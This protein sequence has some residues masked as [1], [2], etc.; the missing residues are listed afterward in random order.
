MNCEPPHP[1]VALLQHAHS[2]MIIAG[3]EAA[4]MLEGRIGDCCDDHPSEAAHHHGLLSPVQQTQF[5]SFSV[6]QASLDS[7]QHSEAFK[8]GY[9]KASQILPYTPLRHS[10]HEPAHA[11][12]HTEVGLMATFYHSCHA[13]AAWPGAVVLDLLDVFCIPSNVL[14]DRFAAGS[15]ARGQHE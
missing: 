14:S 11:A 13:L 1:S 5:D 8:H 9:A 4:P 10:G 2:A 7:A 3:S 15:H 6:G 12:Q